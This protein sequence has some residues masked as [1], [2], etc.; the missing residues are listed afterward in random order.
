MAN[1]YLV[2]AA[3]LSVVGKAWVR[4]VLPKL[5]KHSL[6]AL[7]TANAKAKA[8]AGSKATKGIFS[9][10]EINAFKNSG[11]MKNA[12]GKGL[13]G[14]EANRAVKLATGLAKRQQRKQGI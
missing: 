10:N 3:A 8:L 14:P 11:V 13:T 6:G 1:K 9:T 7:S 5:S 12:I 4:D 2:K